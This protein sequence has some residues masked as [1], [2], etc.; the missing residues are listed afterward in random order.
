MRSLLS[1]DSNS[2]DEGGAIYLEGNSKLHT[3]FFFF[4]YAKII[5]I[6]LRAHEIA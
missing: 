2:A 4:F 6:L 3:L 1:F 5:L